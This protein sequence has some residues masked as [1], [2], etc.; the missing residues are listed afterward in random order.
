MQ[1]KNNRD[2]NQDL[3]SQYVSEFLIDE[4]EIRKVKQ[5]N[6]DVIIFQQRFDGVL[7]TRPISGA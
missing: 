2:A 3:V 6:R 1:R 4:Y 7:R 5:G